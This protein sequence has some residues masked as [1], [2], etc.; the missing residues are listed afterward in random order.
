MEE[1]MAFTVDN[2][3]LDRLNHIVGERLRNNTLRTS[4]I[5][6]HAAGNADDADAARLR[7]DIV[8]RVANI[9]DSAIRE[10]LARASSRLFSSKPS[11]IIA[12]C[13]KE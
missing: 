12:I 10:A 5:V 6:R 13:G 7:A 11:E 1:T 3:T 8:A 2:E 9:S 4:A